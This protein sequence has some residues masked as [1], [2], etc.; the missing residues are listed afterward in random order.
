[1]TLNYKHSIRYTRTISLFQNLR[2][3]H[4]N[5]DDYIPFYRMCI[6]NLIDTPIDKFTK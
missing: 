6:D 2:I 3:K 5:N 4:L 1:M